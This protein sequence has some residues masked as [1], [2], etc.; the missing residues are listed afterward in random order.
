MD[1][2]KWRGYEKPRREWTLATENTRIARHMSCATQP[3]PPLSVRP[4]VRLVIVGGHHWR[5]TSQ[6]ERRVSGAHCRPAS[7]ALQKRFNRKRLC[8]GDSA[9]GQLTLTLSLRWRR[10]LKEHQAK[11]ESAT[12]EPPLPPIKFIVSIFPVVRSFAL[13]WCS[14]GCQTVRN[15]LFSVPLGYSLCVALH[16]DASGEHEHS[17]VP[18]APRRP[19]PL[20]SKS[21]TLP[22]VL[23]VRA[24]GLPRRCAPRAV[25]RVQL[26]RVAGRPRARRGR[27]GAHARSR[28]VHVAARRDGKLWRRV[29]PARRSGA[30]AHLFAEADRPRSESAVRRE[31]RGYT[32][33]LY[34]YIFASST[35]VEINCYINVFTFAV[36][37]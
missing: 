5:L 22:A 34:S 31:L 32:I 28:R 10:L 13:T 16:A 33:V 3:T 36:L 37:Y 20:A 7:R 9:G 29:R 26:H 11:R 23:P 17:F 15:H 24:R 27:A 1:M 19:D 2:W 30:R 14:F 6:G 18:R 4:A 8:A 25:P 12:L 21:R 35:V